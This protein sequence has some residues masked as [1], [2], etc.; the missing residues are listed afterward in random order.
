MPWPPDEHPSAGGSF[1]W[2]YCGDDAG[3]EGYM[4]DLIAPSR[5]GFLAGLG[6]VLI[7]APAIVRASSIMPVRQMLILGPG[8]RMPYLASPMD[9]A[10]VTRRAFMPR[11]Y[12]QIYE[13]SPDFRHLIEAA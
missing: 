11:I 12:V 4:T 8:D 7:T 1:V 2:L 9:I 13:Q 10:A 6:A 5:R 3:Y